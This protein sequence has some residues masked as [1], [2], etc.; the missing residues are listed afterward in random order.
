MPNKGLTDET[1]IEKCERLM[2]EIEAKYGSPADAS[3]DPVAKAN[4]LMDEIERSDADHMAKRTPPAAD[5]LL[6]VSTKHVRELAQRLN[7]QEGPNA[8]TELRKALA[9]RPGF[10]ESFMN[11]P[12]PAKTLG[13]GS[14]IMSREG[15]CK[16]SWIQGQTVDTIAKAVLSDVHPAVILR[17]GLR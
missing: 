7:V 15:L 14:L 8:L 16:G 6:K 4:R 13:A 9:A 10:L 11:E 2:S 5:V 12:E 17:A 1:A 3:D